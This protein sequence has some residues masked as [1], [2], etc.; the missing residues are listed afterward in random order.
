MTTT[1]PALAA[2]IERQQ[3]VDLLYAFARALDEKN[4]TGYADL[5]AD[6]AVL[7]LPWGTTVPKAELAADTEHNLGRFARTHHMS[8]NHQVQVTDD[9]AT[10]R[11]YLQA[12]HVPADGT[13]HWVTGGWYDCEYR[14]VDGSWR[15]TRV[16]LNMVWETGTAPAF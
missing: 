12:V 15:F 14:R 9:T 13:E 3:I 4:W 16:V 7:V 11:S 6:D 10:S 1:D 5:Y 8:T 2:L